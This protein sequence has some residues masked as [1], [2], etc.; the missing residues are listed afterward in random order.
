MIL[1]VEECGAK[2]DLAPD[3][4]A[5]AG[6]SFRCHECGYHNIRKAKGKT[7]SLP[8]RGLSSRLQE[9]TALSGIV[10]AFVFDFKKGVTHHRMPPP[11]TT[12][13][14]D[15]VGRLLV[16]SYLTARQALPDIYQ[17]GLVVAGRN[18]V[19]KRIKKS[20]VLI[21]ASEQFPIHNRVNQHIKESFLNTGGL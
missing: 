21:L 16:Q 7:G 15:L 13:D 20:A 4:A 10:G 3:S 18:M 8:D 19:L 1:F 12:E 2:Y 14:L 5:A 6:T 9:L 17:M 11:L